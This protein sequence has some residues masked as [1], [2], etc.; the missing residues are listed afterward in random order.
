MEANAALRRILRRNS[1]ERYLEM[2]TRRAKESGIG[3]GK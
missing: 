3:Y 2:L 1:G